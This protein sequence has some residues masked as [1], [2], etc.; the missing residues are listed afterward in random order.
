MKKYS[1][2][3]ILIAA[4]LGEVSIIDVKHVISYLDEAVIL[5]R[6]RKLRKKNVSSELDVHECKCIRITGG[7]KWFPNGCKI[8]PNG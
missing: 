5:Q 2:E 3:Q 6:E 7:D 8:H 4:E 1:K